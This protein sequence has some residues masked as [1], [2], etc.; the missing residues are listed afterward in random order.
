MKDLGPQVGWRTVFLVEYV[1]RI[2]ICRYYAPV[3]NQRVC[4]SA[5]SSFIRCC[6]TSLRCF[7]E[8]KFNIAYSRSRLYHLLCE[9]Y[10]ERSLLG[11]ASVWCY[12]ISSNASTRLFCKS[13]HYVLIHND[14]TNWKQRSP[15]LQGHHAIAKHFQKVCRIIHFPFALFSDPELFYLSSFHYHILGGVLLAFDLYRPKYAAFSPAVLG[16]KRDQLSFIWFWS[17]IFVV[18]TLPP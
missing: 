7:M 13:A 15:F 3:L 10:I 11:T 8:A 2:S 17:A 16:T 18:C 12:S 14:L 1:R 9:S 4:R 5:P 6:T